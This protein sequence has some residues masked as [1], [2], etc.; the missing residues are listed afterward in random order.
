MPFV[1]LCAIHSTIRLTILGGPNVDL[2]ITPYPLKIIYE[3]LHTCL[4]SATVDMLPQLE[5]FAGIPITTCI[6]KNY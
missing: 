2:A 4:E 6:C 1:T 5:G 3:E